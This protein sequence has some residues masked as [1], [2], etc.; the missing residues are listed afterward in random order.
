L[1][2]ADVDQVLVAALSH[3]ADLVMKVEGFKTGYS[4][5][6]DGQVRSPIA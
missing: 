3:T 1:A 2:H 4:N 6:E 5:E